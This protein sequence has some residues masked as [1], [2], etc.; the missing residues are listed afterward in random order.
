MPKPASTDLDRD[1][2]PRCRKCGELLRSYSGTGDTCEDCT[3]SRHAAR[4]RQDVIAASRRHQV[5]LGREAGGT[6]TSAGSR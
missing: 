6:D 5:G 1:T 3:V 2:G 4:W